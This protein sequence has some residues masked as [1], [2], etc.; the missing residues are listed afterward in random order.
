MQH[1]LVVRCSVQL[2]KK[3]SHAGGSFPGEVEHPLLHINSR[4]YG[5]CNATFEVYNEASEASNEAF[6]AYNVAYEVSNEAL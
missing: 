3:S 4:E 2:A 6:K 1:E 5:K